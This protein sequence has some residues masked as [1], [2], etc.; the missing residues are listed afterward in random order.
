MLRRCV[1]EH[2]FKDAV[3]SSL[4]NDEKERT[5]FEWFQ[6]HEADILT[7]SIE[8]T[9]LRGFFD[10]EQLVEGQKEILVKL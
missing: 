1:H 7:P 3:R 6:I 9:N 4:A 5:L 8:R 10:V 2:L